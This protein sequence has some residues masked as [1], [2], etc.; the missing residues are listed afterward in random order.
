MGLAIDYKRL[1]GSFQGDGSVLNF[2]Y[3]D[4]YVVVYIVKIYVIV[5]LQRRIVLYVNQIVINFKGK[6]LNE[7]QRFFNIFF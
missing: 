5:F 4:R 2:D 3:G 7:G 1:Y 6:N